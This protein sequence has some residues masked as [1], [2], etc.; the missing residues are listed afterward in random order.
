MVNT[1]IILFLL[2]IIV[3]FSIIYYRLRKILKTLKDENVKLLSSKKKS[4]I[5]TGQVAEKLV[6]FLEDFKHDPQHIQFLGQPIDYISFEKDKIVIIEVKSGNSKLNS[7]QR[8]IR[9]LIKNGK[10]EWELYRIK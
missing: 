10:V 4:E 1:L 2:I 7:K 6:P 3:L 8:N 5:V 9:D